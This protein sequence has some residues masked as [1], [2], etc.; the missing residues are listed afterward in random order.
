MEVHSVSYEVRRQVLT[1]ALEIEEE[2]SFENTASF[3]LLSCYMYTQSG[4]KASITQ[5]LPQDLLHQVVLLCYFACKKGK[6]QPRR[7][8]E[9]LLLI[10]ICIV[11]RF[12]FSFLLL[13][14]PT[15]LSFFLFIGEKNLRN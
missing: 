3:F 12:C 14:W 2:H 13:S 1:G 15:L 6:C 11:T 7:N 8:P 5:S 4:C 9:I 10:N